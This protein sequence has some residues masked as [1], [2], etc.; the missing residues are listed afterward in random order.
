MIV[1]NLFKLKENIM[2]MANNVQI[3]LEKCIEG[4]SNNDIKCLEEILYFEDIVNRF[5]IE[6]ERLCTN[7]IALYHPEAKDLRTVLMIYKINSD[8]ERIAD[9]AVNITDSAKFLIKR[10]PLNLISDI[11]KMAKLTLLMFNDCIVAF[12]NED[13]KLSRNICE[14]DNQ[15][16]QLNKDIIAN[17]I[18]NIKADTDIIE[19]AFHIHRIS[20]NLE[21]TAD[22]TTNI[23]EEII[24]MVQGKVIK[25][26]W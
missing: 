22:L 12:N 25:H 19:R 4:L 26:K 6:I 8:M 20:K 17:L 23:A 18:T 10:L 3:M 21:R 16:D 5:E 14:R 9:Q 1:K 2:A 15:I 7:T 13:V 24:F 11:I